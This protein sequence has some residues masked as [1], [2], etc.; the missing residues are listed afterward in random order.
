M[1]ITYDNDIN[2]SNTFINDNQ[3]PGTATRSLWSTVLHA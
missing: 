2:I 1:F 3:A